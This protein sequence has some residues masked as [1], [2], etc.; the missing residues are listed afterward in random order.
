[1]SD[2]AKLVIKRFPENR[3]MQLVSLRTP[4]R[5]HCSRCNMPQRSKVLALVSADWGQLL[6][7]VCYEKVLSEKL[8]EPV[9]Q[10]PPEDTSDDASR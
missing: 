4:A 8:E 9:E 5:F 2:L 6:C 7:P 10:A 1:M 3:G